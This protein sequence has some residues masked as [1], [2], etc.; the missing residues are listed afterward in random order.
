M[1]VVTTLLSQVSIEGLI[2]FLVMG[3]AAIKV[4]SELFEWGYNKIK[5]FFENNNENAELKRDIVQRLEK[6]EKLLDQKNLEVKAIQ[7]ELIFINKR[8]QDNTKCFITDKYH[9]YVKE[10]GRIDEAGLQELEIRYQYFI[11]GGGNDNLIDNRMEEIRELP[12]MTPDQ[13]IRMRDDTKRS[14]NKRLSEL[15]ERS[16]MK[17]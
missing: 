9:Y 11:E 12:V 16:D 13:L 10:L 15:D 6:I 1:D 17:E 5:K 7:N 2:I 4:I 3:L 8:L 14:Y